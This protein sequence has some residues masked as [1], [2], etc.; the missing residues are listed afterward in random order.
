MSSLDEAMK[1]VNTKYLETDLTRK[2]QIAAVN[3]KIREDIG[4]ILCALFMP[5]FMV[6]FLKSVNYILDKQ[7]VP[8]MDDIELLLFAENGMKVVFSLLVI[9]AFYY[10]PVFAHRLIGN[11][12]EKHGLQRNFRVYGFNG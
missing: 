10:V 7:G 11:I 9:S 12:K 4:A 2:G 8:P 1:P 6:L 3:E 5:V